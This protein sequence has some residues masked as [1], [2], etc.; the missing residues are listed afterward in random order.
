VANFLPTDGYSRGAESPVL[1][2]DPTLFFRAGAEN[3]C[4]V[5]ADQVVDLTGGSRYAS[6][7]PDEA[8]SDMVQTVMAI[9]PSDKRFGSAQQILKEHFTAATKTGAKAGDSLKS[10]FVLACLAPSSV[11]RGM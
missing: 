3:L 4:R 1:A 5:L 11:A 10:T 7:K 6:T 2:N 8:I 9:T